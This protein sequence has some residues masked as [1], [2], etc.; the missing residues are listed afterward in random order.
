MQT[1]TKACK[2]FHAQHGRYPESLS[3]ITDLMDQGQ[4]AL[5]DPWGNQYQIQFIQNQSDATGTSQQP[6]VFTTAPDGTKISQYGID[7]YPF[8]SA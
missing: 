6:L 3:E 5:T 1:L 7:K 8:K 2:T 4:H